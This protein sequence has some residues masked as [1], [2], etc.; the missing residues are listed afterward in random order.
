[1]KSI[2]RVF[3]VLFSLLIIISCSNNV[4]NEHEQLYLDTADSLQ[5]YH[6]LTTIQSELDSAGEMQDYLS[7]TFEEF[8]KKYKADDAAVDLISKSLQITIDLAKVLQ[9]IENNKLKIESLKSI[10]LDT[11]DLKQEDYSFNRVRE[12]GF[13]DSLSDDNQV[14]QVM[15][16]K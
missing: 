13:S 7:L 8:K 4:P 2:L 15:M 12:I 3:T 14:I 6:D 5:L 11:I 10:D 9:S 1:M 16:A